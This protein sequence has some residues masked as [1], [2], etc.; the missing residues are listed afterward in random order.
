MDSSKRLPLRTLL[1]FIIV[2][3]I[4]VAAFLVPV[5]YSGQSTTLV[6]ILSSKIGECLGSFMKYIVMLVMAISAV[7]SAS[8]YI[9]RKSGKPVPGWLIKHFGTTPLYIIT[10]IL[11]FIFTVMYYFNIGPERFLKASSSMVELGGTMVSLA[12]ALSFFL[13]FLTDGG[14]MEFVGELLRPFVRPLFKVPSEASLDLLASWIGASDAAAILSANK[15]RDGYYTKRE[16]A[17][18]MCNF[19]LVSVSFCMVVAQVAGVAEY[20]PHM[21][22][23]LCVLGILLAIIIPRI[24]PIRKLENVY[25]A[26]KP[27]V[28][29]M[30]HS[31]NIFRRA[32]I[33]GCSVAENFTAKKVINTG[34]NTICSVLLGVVTV[35]IGWGV[36]GMVV[37]EMTPIFEWLSI[38][39][40]W[41]LDL[42]GVESAYTIAP[43]TLVGFIDMY[44]PALLVTGVGSIKSRFIIA[45]LSLIQIVYVTI[46]GAVVMQCKLGLDI[47]KLFLVF[48][49]R[50]IIALPIIVLF[51][52][53]FIK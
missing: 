38:P 42:L 11:T 41:Y 27:D 30:D 18:V 10:K 23:L 20:F 26:Q 44:I 32:L 25:I 51:A 50:T 43:A 45:A 8:E 49:E 31:V 4:G 53:L 48:I 14:L 2:S 3:F 15:Y 33:K 24:Y 13:V 17:S 7:G 40:G 1:K 46:V 37:V 12:L 34:I 39:M 21:Y 52:N 22:L 19:S 36:I 9:L 6:S 16:A 5:T 35:G 28:P 47:K 29:E